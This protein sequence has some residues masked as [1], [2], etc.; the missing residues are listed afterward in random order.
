MCRWRP[1]SPKRPY[2]VRP[3]RVT[4]AATPFWALKRPLTV[5]ILGSDGTQGKAGGE[6]DNDTGDVP[7]VR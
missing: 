2:L 1:P 6:G 7:N 4:L 3:Q 5:P